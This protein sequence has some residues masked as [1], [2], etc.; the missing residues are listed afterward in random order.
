MT[1]HTITELCAIKSEALKEGKLKISP[2]GQVTGLDGRV[3]YIDGQTITQRLVDTGLELVLNVAH[4]YGGQAAGWFSDFEL[5]EDGIYARLRLNEHG[6]DLLARQA[7]K[8][9]S[10]EYFANGYTNRQVLRL[11][12]VALVNQPNLLNDA[13]NQLQPPADT[14]T[15]DMTMTQTNDTTDPSVIDQLKQDN[16]ALAEQNA[17]LVKQIQT[18]KVDQA[19]ASG[20]L[21]PARREFALTLEGQ[22]LDDY[23]KLEAEAGKTSQGI[24][25]DEAAGT[26]A[27]AACPILSQLNLSEDHKDG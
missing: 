10:P 25:P 24:R 8:Y 23:L 14:H 1:I 13:L 7:Y 11:V 21:L 9:L 16:A 18:Q 6:T 19:V 3:F 17:E 27:D 5:R 12:G 2:I 4:E 20:R 22:T 26:D 15:Q